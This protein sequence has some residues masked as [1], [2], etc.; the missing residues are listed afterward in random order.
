MYFIMT[1]PIFLLPYLFISLFWL[2]MFLKKEK[3]KAME[4]YGKPCFPTQALVHIKLL[5]F[6]RVLDIFGILS[7]GYEKRLNT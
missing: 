3:R 6:D 5:S 2:D 7:R 1:S 4:C